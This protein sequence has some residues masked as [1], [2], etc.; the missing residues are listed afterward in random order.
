MLEHREQGARGWVLFMGALQ[1]FGSVVKTAC[2]SL[3]LQ[4]RKRRRKKKAKK[5][6]RKKKTKTKQPQS[7]QWLSRGLQCQSRLLRPLC[8]QTS[9]F[10]ACMSR[11]TDGILAVFG[12][13]GAQRRFWALGPSQCLWHLPCVHPWVI[14][15]ASLNPSSELWDPSIALCPAPNLQSS[16]SL[17]ADPS[18]EPDVP[19]ADGQGE[20]EEASAA[21]GELSPN[22]LHPTPS[23]PPHFQ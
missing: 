23:S 11:P 20:E 4:T 18:S 22:P 9:A 1:L 3:G 10:P 16:G 14:P 7:S 8:F 19:F 2:S 6:E 21:N 15:R 5:E 17:A 13:P 12:A